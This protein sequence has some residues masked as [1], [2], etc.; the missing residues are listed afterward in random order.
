MFTAGVYYFSCWLSYGSVS[1]A[2][3]VRIVGHQWFGSTIILR[4][5]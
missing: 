3:G 1:A 2:Y 4:A 5:S